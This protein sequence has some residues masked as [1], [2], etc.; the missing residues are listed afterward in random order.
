MDNLGF[1]G[2]FKKG[3][4]TLDIQL[5]LFQFTEEDLIFIYSPYLDLTGYGKTENEAIESFKET[6]L[7]FINYTDHKKTL[8]KELIRLGWKVIKKRRKPNSDENRIK[9][10]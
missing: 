1:L 3:S 4:S 5:T 7:E 6:L 9:S 2:K 10:S 8:E